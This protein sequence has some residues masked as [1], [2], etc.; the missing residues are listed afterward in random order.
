MTFFQHR[1]KKHFSLTFF[2]WFL[3]RDSNYNFFCHQSLAPC[4]NRWLQ[5]WDSSQL[6]AVGFKGICPFRWRWRAS[7]AALG[8]ALPADWGRSSFPS[9]TPE[10]MCQVLGSQVQDRYRLTEAS[11]AERQE[12]DYRIHHT[13]RGWESCG[14][15]ASGKSSRWLLSMCIPDMRM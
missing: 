14:C 15:S 12:N 11:V 3:L 6:D 13:Q 4:Y 9:E 2:D 7:W 10:M 5:S 1:K 8:K